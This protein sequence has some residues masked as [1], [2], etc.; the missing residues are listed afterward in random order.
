[1]SDMLA[2]STTSNTEKMMLFRWSF[3][4]VERSLIIF[5][6]DVH[7]VYNRG[8]YNNTFGVTRTRTKN[9][10]NIQISKS[11]VCVK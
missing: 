7:I 9:K 6:K 10:V 4:S 3:D 8:A 2:R 1:M 11:K 5:L